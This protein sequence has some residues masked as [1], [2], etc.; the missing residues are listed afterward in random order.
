MAYL[1]TSNFRRR[2]KLLLVLILTL[3]YSI[4]KTII[5][6]MDLQTLRLQQCLIY[7]PRRLGIRVTFLIVRKLASIEELIQPEAF[8][9]LDI[10]S[11]M[12]LLLIIP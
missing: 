4:K 3:A 11:T 9:G 2:K 1:F 5:L 8:P 6:E 12:E 10:I 7:R